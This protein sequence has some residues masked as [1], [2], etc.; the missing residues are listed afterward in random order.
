MYVVHT[1]LEQNTAQTSAYRNFNRYVSDTPLIRECV[2]E[3]L[4]THI[5]CSTSAYEEYELRREEYELRM[6]TYVLC[7]RDVPF[8]S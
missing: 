5:K 4:S 1:S 7:T 8:V 6:L 3:L 2:T